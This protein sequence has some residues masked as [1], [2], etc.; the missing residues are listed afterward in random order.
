MN[1]FLNDIRSFHQVND[2]EILKK[3]STEEKYTIF[4][5][6]IRENFE[7]LPEETRID[8]LSFFDLIEVEYHLSNKL[9]FLLPEDKISKGFE[10]Y[11]LNAATANELMNS[12]E[13]E[14]RGG[15]LELGSFTASSL[16]SQIPYDYNNYFSDLAEISKKLTSEPIGLLIMSHDSIHA[17]S[18]VYFPQDDTWLLTD[19]ENLPTISLK[20][21]S[22]V[23][24]AVNEYLFAL[25]DYE[26]D[27]YEF[28]PLG[29][30]INVFSLGENAKQNY[31]VFS[32]WNAMEIIYMDKQ[33][34][35]ASDYHI[36]V[37][38]AANHLDKVLTDCNSSEEANAIVVLLEHVKKCSFKLQTI[39]NM[40]EC[41]GITSKLSNQC[42]S[43]QSLNNL[44]GIEEAIN[45]LKN[46]HNEID[47]AY[48]NGWKRYAAQ[49]KSKSD[50]TPTTDFYSFFYNSAKQVSDEI[51]N[52]FKRT[53]PP[54][55]KQKNNNSDQ[56]KQKK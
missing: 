18:L 7:N 14:K 23:A 35:D 40:D 55:D 13:A 51:Y 6:K 22:E 49:K 27:Q 39:K 26:P 47:E 11:T 33:I 45:N 2:N 21:P 37:S 32:R 29:I 41:P 34:M 46:I 50:Q 36:S 42:D 10:N 3:M 38:N 4:N 24:G 30:N 43:F 52:F 53:P 28:M 8:I 17:I 20:N 15:L 5:N 48:T 12:I 25:L 56:F 54:E 44:K 16:K 9:S 19:A 31:E 1:N